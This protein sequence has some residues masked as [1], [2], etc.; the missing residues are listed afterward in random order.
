MTIQP[1][2]SHNPYANGTSPELKPPAPKAPQQQAQDSVQL[3]SKAKSSGG[4]HHE[5]DS[6]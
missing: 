6:R 4:V 3:S 2:S 5:G 1:T